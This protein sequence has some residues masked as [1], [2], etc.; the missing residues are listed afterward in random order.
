MKYILVI[1]LL[2]AGKDLHAQAG[3]RMHKGWWRAQLERGDGKLVVFNMETVKQN[4]RWLFFIRNDKERIGLK[5]ITIN[6]DSVN[7][8]MPVFESEFKTTLQPDGSLKGKWFKGTALQTQQWNFTAIPTKKDRFDAI[9]GAPKFDVSGRW[10]VAITRPNGTRRPAVAELKQKGSYLSGTFL[11]PSGDYR[12]LEGIV[13]GQLLFLSVFDGAHAYSFTADI[14]DSNSIANGFFYSGY[15]GKEA[16]TALRDDDAKVPDVG[17][18]PELR[19]GEERLNFAFKDLYRNTV[20]INDARFQNKVV[21]IQ[22]MGSWC[23]NCMDETK[24]LNEYYLKNRDRGVEV[25]SLAYEYSTDYERS[26]TSLLKFQQRFNVQYPMLITG[27]WVNDSLRTE[28]TLPQ[29]TPIKVFPTTIFIGK[30]GRVQKF[31]S[32]FYGPG[33][34]EYYELF[35]K[36]FEETIEELLRK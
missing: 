27:A 23:P 31:H 10:A 9:V 29:I 25:V 30:D 12:Y 24:F 33:T 21:V 5:N 17:N 8:A 35:K 19:A 34:G 28:K 22:L 2:V 7:F 36:E 11:T 3:R 15:N 14:I 16:W 1:A 6:G 20:S 32:G 13:T 26:R 18:T 4:N